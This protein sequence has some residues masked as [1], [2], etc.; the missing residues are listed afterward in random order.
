MGFIS[1]LLG[2]TSEISAAPAEHGVIVKFDYLGTTDLAPLFALEE[3]LEAAINAARVGEFDGNEVAA[4]GSDGVLYMY[5]PD[6]DRLFEA[7]R[8]VLEGVPSCAAH[9]SL[10]DTVRL[11]PK[12]GGV[13]SSLDPDK[14]RDRGSGPGGQ[15]RWSPL[16]ANDNHHPVDTDILRT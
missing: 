9:T 3:R 5:G 8:P 13:S 15:A 4:D 1:R 6:A 11:P 7:I 16:T 12:S 14:R 10:C 2:K